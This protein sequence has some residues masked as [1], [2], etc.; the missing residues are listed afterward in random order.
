MSNKS[1][2][3]INVTGGGT[4]KDIVLAL[5][6]AINALEYGKQDEVDEQI[7]EVYIE[8]FELAPW[9]IADAMDAGAFPE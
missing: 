4:K 6:S 5:R 7:G 2:F 9:D 3:S 8:I 1:L